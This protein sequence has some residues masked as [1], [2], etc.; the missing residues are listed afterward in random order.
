LPWTDVAVVAMD[1]VDASASGAHKRGGFEAVDA[2]HCDIEDD[3]N[4]VVIEQRAECFI[5][6]L[7]LD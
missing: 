5:A 3:G 4:A 7:R 1:D 2:G 6:G